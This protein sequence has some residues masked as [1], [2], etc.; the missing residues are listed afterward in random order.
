[1]ADYKWTP[2]DFDQIHLFR[3]NGVYSKLAA[4]RGTQPSDVFILQG[5]I[6]HMTLVAMQYHEPGR[7]VRWGLRLVRQMARGKLEFADIELSWSRIYRLL[8]P[9][10]GD[11]HF[12]E[13][14]P[15]E[16]DLIDTAPARWFWVLP[17]SVLPH[18]F[19]L[20]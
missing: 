2:A 20:K 6:Q 7:Y 17:R 15:R 3:E 19:N 5:T 13:V 1:M 4:K 12:I 10:I 16:C 8:Q 18:S 9:L 14:Y 11:K